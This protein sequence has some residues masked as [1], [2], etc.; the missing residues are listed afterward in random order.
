M[1]LLI[2]F[3][4]MLSN[5]FASDATGIKNLVINEELKNYGDITFLD[6]KNKELNL[7]DFKGNLVIL[8]FWATWCAPCKDEMPSLDLLIENPNLDNLKIFPINIGKDTNQKSLTFFEDLKIKNLE[9]YFDS[10]NTLAKKFK[11]RGLPTTIFFNKEGLEFAR[12]IGSIDFIDE[13]FMKWL[14]NYN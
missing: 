11:L 12:I 14:T 7:N 3:I 10:P 6:I 4:L 13:K 8:N 2:I 5:S 9:V 1:R